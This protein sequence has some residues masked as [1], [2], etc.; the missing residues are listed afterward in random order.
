MKRL[1][2]VLCV[3]LIFLLVVWLVIYMRRPNSGYQA[4]MRD[5]DIVIYDISDLEMQAAEI[6][7]QG[8]FDYI[9]GG[10][11]TE[12][13]LHRNVTAFDNVDIWFCYRM[14]CHENCTTVFVW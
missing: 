11:E 8:G 2:F 6:I 3:I 9:R 7:P 1:I 13:T 14:F 12:Q 5:S 10:A 4:S